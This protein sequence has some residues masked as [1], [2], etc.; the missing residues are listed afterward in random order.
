MICL[1]RDEA[2]T[3]AL[4]RGLAEHCPPGAVIWLRGPLG[5]GKTT[6][7][8]GFLRALGYQGAVKSP[9]YTLIEPYECRGRRIFHLDLYRIADPSELDFLGLREL[10]DEESV[11]LVEWPERGVAALPPADLTLELDY[12]AS[13]RR[14]RLQAQSGAGEALARAASPFSAE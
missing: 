1:L 9:T 5:A 2:D 8:R 14:A 4:G 6:L 10:H 7:V 3:V 13:G 11:L 12:D